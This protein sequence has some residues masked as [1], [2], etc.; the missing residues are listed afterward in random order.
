VYKTHI[1]RLFVGS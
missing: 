1:H